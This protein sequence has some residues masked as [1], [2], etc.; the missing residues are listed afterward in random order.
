M[1]IHGEAPD[2]PTPLRAV[3][4]PGRGARGVLITEGRPWNDPEGGASKRRN[5]RIFAPKPEARQDS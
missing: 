1:A 3:R 5:K 2:S 4:L